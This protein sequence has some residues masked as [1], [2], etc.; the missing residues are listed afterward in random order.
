[1]S[2]RCI[3][4]LATQ[5]LL[6]ETA[7]WPK[8]G[9][10]SPMDA[11]SHNDMDAPLLQHSARTLE[12]WF[13]ELAAAGAA[14]A[15]LACLREIGCA[16]EVAMLLATGGINTH[17]GAIFGLG[18]L[19]AAAGLTGTDLRRSQPSLGSVVRRCWGDALASPMPLPQRDDRLDSHGSQVERRY[20][21]GGARAEAMRGFDSVYHVALPALRHAQRLRPGDGNAARVQACFALMA[22][23]EDTNLLFRG[24]IEGLQLVHRLAQTFIDRG[25]VANPDWQA[26]ALS[27]HA[28]LVQRRLSPGGCADLLAMSLFV[29]GWAALRRQYRARQNSRRAPARCVAALA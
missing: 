13:V 15:S 4:A 5:A 19:C 26:E 14:H 7:T 27:T 3:G 9:L 2:M 25:G 24:G 11:G 8:P 17:R 16:A 23:V 10:V 20:G 6:L 28:V 29:D 22:R 18:L 1:M 12:P 21:A